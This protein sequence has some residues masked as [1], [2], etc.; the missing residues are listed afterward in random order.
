MQTPIHL[1]F[2]IQEAMALV[3]A[4]NTAYLR[5]E[6]ELNLTSSDLPGERNRLRKKMATM[7]EAK[8]KIKTAC[9]HRD[10]MH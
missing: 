2:T 4:C 10:A 5:L 9:I 6:A 3:D 7:Q 1:D 8:E